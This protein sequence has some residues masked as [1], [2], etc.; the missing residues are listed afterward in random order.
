[1]ASKILRTAE[2]PYM[3]HT[4]RVELEPVSA[5][6]SRAKNPAVTG[7]RGAAA[8]AMSA[9]S[10]GAAIDSDAFV[11]HGGLWPRGW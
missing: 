1:M 8:K 3:T 4:W 7:A 9:A 6:P 2:S 5:N 11:S 10:G